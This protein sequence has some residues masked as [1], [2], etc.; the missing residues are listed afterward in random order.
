MIYHGDNFFVEPEAPSLV[1]VN[2]EFA[3]YTE[4]SVIE[5]AGTTAVI[6]LDAFASLDAAAAAVAEDGT[7]EVIGGMVSFANGCDANIVVDAGAT[8]VGTAVFNRPITI[9][10]T[11]VFDTG[12]T[13]MGMTAQ[14]Q[15]LSFV[16]GAMNYTLNDY[17]GTVGAY[18]L[19]TDA[20]SFN[21]AVSFYGMAL[22][23]GE[24]C[25]IEGKTYTLGLTDNNDLILTINEYAPPQADV[26]APV[27]EGLYADVTGSTA[28]SVTS[29]PFSRMTRAWITSCTELA[30][31]APGR[32]ITA[33]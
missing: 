9:N 25:V 18:I 33:A 2:S 17:S 24:T 19:A 13:N 3:D 27:L 12:Y 31:T 6:G 16:S 22:T 15:G 21:S 32:T 30:T 5:I 10:G 26:T 7:V 8:V 4:G 11:I 20:A 14:Y 29:R 1:Y 28:G 23:L